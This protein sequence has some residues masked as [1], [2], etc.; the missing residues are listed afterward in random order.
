M[1]QVHRLPVTFLKS[2]KVSGTLPSYTSASQNCQFDSGSMKRKL[3]SNHSKNFQF[4]ITCLSTASYGPSAAAFPHRRTSLRRFR[5]FHS[6]H[7]RTGRPGI[8]T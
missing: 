4:Y 2:L 1:E 3:E 7:R 8:R 5:E 6:L